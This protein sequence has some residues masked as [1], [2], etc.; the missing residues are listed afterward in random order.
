MAHDACA[1]PMRT[2]WCPRRLTHQCCSLS[3]VCVLVS[4]GTSA[5]GSQLLSSFPLPAAWTLL[6][7][8]SLLPAHSTLFTSA[9]SIRGATISLRRSSLATHP[10]ALVL[11]IVGLPMPP[12]VDG[13][14]MFARSVHGGTRESGLRTEQGH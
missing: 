8:P 2:L 7:P 3:A 12:H 1:W 4:L 10:R 5:G 14:R 9:E 6:D 11:E 13:M